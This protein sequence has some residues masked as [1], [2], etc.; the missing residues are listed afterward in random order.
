MKSAL[1]DLAMKLG[2]LVI[3]VDEPVILAGDD[4]DRHFQLAVAFLS[5]DGTGDHQGGFRRAGTDLRRPHGHLG[6]KRLELLRDLCGPNILRMS[7]GHMSAAQ[8]GEMV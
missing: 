3:D 4:D 5:G 7:K 8:K 6:R 2:R 1:R